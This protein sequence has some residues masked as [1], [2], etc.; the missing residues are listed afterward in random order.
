[1]V[2]KI[3]SF[4]KNNTVLIVID[5]QYNSDGYWGTYGWD[6]T[7]SNCKLVLESCRSKGYPIVHLM[8]AMDPAGVLCHPLDP[9]DKDG[10][11]ICSVKGDRETEIVDELKPLP[12]EIVIEKQR[13]SAFYQTNLDLVLQGLKAEHLIMI[14]CFTDACYLTSA[15]DAFQR[16]FPISI[17]KDACTAGTEAAHKASILIMANWVYGC[18][19]FNA[20]ELVKA[21]NDEKYAAWFW[22][23]PNSMPFELHNIQEQYQKLDLDSEEVG[24]PLSQGS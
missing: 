3:P 9:R 1:M 2:G 12:G 18:S 13:D 7:V 8:V 14:G 15:Y 23:Q 5:M 16:G 24:S 6:D 20:K 4:N 21:L 10:N 17:I 19:I 22:D 11:P